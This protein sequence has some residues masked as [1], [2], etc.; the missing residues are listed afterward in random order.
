MERILC[1]EDAHQ[2]YGFDTVEVRYTTVSNNTVDWE[3]IG[4]GGAL[5]VNH[6]A[7]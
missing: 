4:R 2:G 6:E 1:M 3:G 5:K 7:C